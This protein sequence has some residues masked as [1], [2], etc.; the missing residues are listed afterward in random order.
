[1][2]TWT[3]LNVGGTAARGS[4]GEGGCVEDLRLFMGQ[5]YG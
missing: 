5:S 1:L 3:A 2:E 4:P